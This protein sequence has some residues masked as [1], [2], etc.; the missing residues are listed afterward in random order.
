MNL[1]RRLLSYHFGYSFYNLL[2]LTYNSFVIYIRYFYCY[3]H[4]VLMRI[5]VRYGREIY[6]IGPEIGE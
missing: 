2:R 5:R 1:G 3:C 4:V 6:H